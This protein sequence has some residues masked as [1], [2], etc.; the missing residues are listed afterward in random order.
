MS[1]AGRTRYRLTF[2]KTEAMRFT[3]HLDVHR[4]WERTFRRAGLPLAYSQGF[5]PRPRLNIGAA[6]PLGCLSRGDLLDAWLETPVPLEELERSLR[7]A[8]PPGLQVVSVAQADEHEPALQRQIVSAVYQVHL[9]PAPASGQVEARIEQFLSAP[10][11]PRQRRGKSYDL[12][13]LV[14]GL[15]LDRTSGELEMQLAAREGA[16]GRPEEVLD[17]LG[18]DP[19]AYAPVRT[20]LVLAGAAGTQVPGPPEAGLTREA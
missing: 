6:L 2:A 11:L 19:A 14:E 17:A 10:A 20:R 16:A 5:N 12:R 13:P 9:G 15:R 18:L 1:A 8:E 7:R 3:G 4:T